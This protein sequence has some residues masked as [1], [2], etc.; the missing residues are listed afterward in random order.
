MKSLN[1]IVLAAVGVALAGVGLNASAINSVSTT[2]NPSLTLTNACSIDTSGLNVTFPNTPAGTVAS[3]ALA[4][5]PVKV[6]C[7]GK[8][9]KLGANI[10]LNHA[11][12]VIA[13]GDATSRG[14]RV[15]SAG[16]AIVYTLLNGATPWGNATLTGAD[17]TMAVIDMATN[18]APAGE[19]YT[20]NGVATVLGSEVAGAYTDTVTLLLEW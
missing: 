19:T 12:A 15:G 8:P 18:G 3:P 6:V 9:Y 1:K 11:A 17:N 16:V 13:G 5:T 14:L 10:G 2:I 7:N 4:G 20:I